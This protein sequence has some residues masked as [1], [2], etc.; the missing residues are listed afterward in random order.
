MNN[1]FS[2]N[3]KK[4]RKENNFSQEQLADIVGVSRQAISKWES[5]QAYPEMDKI[6]MLCEKFNVNIDDLLHKDI[7]EAKGETETKKKINTYMDNFLNFITD[8]VNMFFNMNLKSKVKCIIEQL[9]LAS[10]LLIIF[11]I[12]GEIIGE[13][14][15]Y[16]SILPDRIYHVI[17][18][19]IEGVYILA[20]FIIS[21]IIIVH[22]F[23]VR[24]LNYY[25]ET[26]NKSKEKNENFKDNEPKIIIR[27][28]K[29]SD[30]SFIRGLYKIFIKLIKLMSIILL[31]AL[32]I[33]LIIILGL[34]I[35]TF[36]INK[37]GLLFIGL[38]GLTISSGTII[39]VLM[40]ITF[41]FIFN[42]KTEKKKTIWTILISIIIFGIS[43]GLTLQGTLN[44]EIIKN[45][46]NYIKTETLE[47]QME[48]DLFFNSYKEIEYIEKNIENIEIEYSINKYCDI[49][50][51]ERDYGEKAIQTYC[52]SP[53]KY[54]KEHIK[55]LN[56]KKI[57][58]IDEEQ[59]SIKI[60]TN[61]ENIKKLKSNYNKIY[62]VNN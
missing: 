62:N 9:I 16:L 28:P 50:I 49:K 2:E 33:T 35:M 29:H 53:K 26:K 34:L 6:I 15:H 17:R 1:K 13:L 10:I 12:V 59:L 60:Y 38:L 11:L 4:I 40:L 58:D 39:F 36:M 46:E 41:N 54:L 25:N 22:I 31:L 57:I 51:T 43:I 7:K 55:N 8:T 27:D 5:S 47:Y 45:D 61:K 18:S 42:R 24:Y 21:I 19:F 32:S 20:S 37:T 30:Y 3:L 23:K 52:Y 56:N 14:T 44:I 48:E